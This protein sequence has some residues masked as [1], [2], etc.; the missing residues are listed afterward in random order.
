MDSV[1]VGAEAELGTIG[2]L[3]PFPQLTNASET[4]ITPS[5]PMNAWRSTERGSQLMLFF[6]QS[7][8]RKK[9]ST[10]LRT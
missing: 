1:V 8:Y 7:Q 5:R 10:L 4:T 2:L 3:F 9:L 6:Q